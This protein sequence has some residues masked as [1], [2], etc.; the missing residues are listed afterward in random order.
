MD[1]VSM[2]KDLLEN[3]IDFLHVPASQEVS[4]LM[5][6]EYFVLNYLFMH[7]H[8]AYPK[9][10]HRSMS[11]SSARIAALLNHMEEKGLVIRTPDHKDNRQV[12]VHLTSKGY[13]LIE[14]KRKEAVTA[15]VR[16]LEFLGPED[17]QTYIRIQKKITTHYRSK[18]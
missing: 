2:A 3:H 12:L 17:A 6:G 7:H 10:L 14:E 18:S 9:E 11:V 1:Y 15:I 16:L 13:T 5:K 8:V 4:N